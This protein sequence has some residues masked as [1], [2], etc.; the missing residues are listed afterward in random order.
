MTLPPLT[1]TRKLEKVQE[2]CPST[3][4]HPMSGVAARDQLLVALLTTAGEVDRD[5]VKVRLA[6]GEGQLVVVH[7]GRVGHVQRAGAPQGGPRCQSKQVLRQN[8]PS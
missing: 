3:G 1:Q 7:Q 5:L 2:I 8:V 6:E 4:V